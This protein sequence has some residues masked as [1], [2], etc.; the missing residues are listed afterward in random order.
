MDLHFAASAIYI[1]CIIHV[2]VEPLCTMLI[3]VRWKT[4]PTRKIENI[5]NIYIYIYL[6]DIR[7]EK[8]VICS[9]DAQVLAVCIK[10]ILV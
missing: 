7:Y 1:G 5:S 2:Y 3:C 6:P 8:S 4:L 10:L 9:F